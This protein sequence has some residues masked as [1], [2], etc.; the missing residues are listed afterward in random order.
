M[1]QKRLKTKNVSLSVEL[2]LIENHLLYFF[3]SYG[4]VAM[5]M[6]SGMGSA[7]IFEYPGETP[8]AKL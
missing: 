4:V 7:A 2:D 1:E 6:A 5:C 3:R 8:E